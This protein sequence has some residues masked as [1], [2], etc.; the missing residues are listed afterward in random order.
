MEEKIFFTADT[1]FNHPAI[2][3]FCRRPFSTVEEMNQALIENWNRVVGKKDRIYIVGDFAFQNHRDFLDRLHGNKHLIIGNHDNMN[4]E[5]LNRFVSVSDYKKIEINHRIYVMNH[6]PLR[7]WDDCHKGSVLLYGHTH[8]RI[9]TYNLSF[10]VGV[11]THNFIPYELSEIKKMIAEREREMEHAHR[12]VKNDK[13]LKQYYQD[14]VQY[15]EF[16]LKKNNVFINKRVSQKGQE[17]E[18][19]Q[20]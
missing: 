1:H 4:L 16:L 18:N 17:E 9:N 13:G 20:N 7:S 10:D 12:I 15:L 2:L 14:D 8:G 5:T 6:A 11:D 19:G 3:K